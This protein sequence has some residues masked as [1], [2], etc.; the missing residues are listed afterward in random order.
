VT[1]GGEGR[2]PI[3]AVGFSHQKITASVIRAASSAQINQYH[4]IRWILAKKKIR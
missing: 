3:N 2:R 4:S 1:A